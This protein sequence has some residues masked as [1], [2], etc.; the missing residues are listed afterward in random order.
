MIMT[1]FYGECNVLD[2]G[3]FLGLKCD[4]ENFGGF[5]MVPGLWA[6]GMQL[7]MI[8]DAAALKDVGYDVQVLDEEKMIWS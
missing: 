4:N 1:V 7:E 8:S 6:D 3:D 5:Q 2:F